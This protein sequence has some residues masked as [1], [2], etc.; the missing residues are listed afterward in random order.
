[1]TLFDQ[2]IAERAQ[3]VFA[4]HT[5]HAYQPDRSIG[6]ELTLRSLNTNFETWSCFGRGRSV[7]TAKWD[8]ADRM[9]RTIPIRH[10]QDSDRAG[11]K[12]GSVL[13]EGLEFD[14]V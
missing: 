3:E 14:R 12:V 10:P 7:S 4:P 8:S 2:M 9:L 6:T 13:R 11:L 5:V 1:M